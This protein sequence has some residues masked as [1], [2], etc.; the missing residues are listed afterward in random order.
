[1]LFVHLVQDDVLSKFHDLEALG[2][3]HSYFALQEY[4]IEGL[5]RK[6]EFL[7]STQRRF[8]QVL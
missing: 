2:A 3:K 4:E 5:G 7:G 8:I 1:M 6:E